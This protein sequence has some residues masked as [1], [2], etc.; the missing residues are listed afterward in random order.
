MKLEID[1]F[2][3]KPKVRSGKKPM[4]RVSFLRI[5][6]SLAGELDESALSSRHSRR[7]RKIKSGYFV[8]EAGTTTGSEQGCDQGED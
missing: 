1:R 2:Y 7:R 4:R 8:C 6:S 5:L 3:G